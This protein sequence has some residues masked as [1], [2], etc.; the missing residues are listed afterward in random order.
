M[1]N[2][3]NLLDKTKSQIKLLDSLFNE[4]SRTKEDR[5]FQLEQV[6]EWIEDEIEEMRA[7]QRFQLEQKIADWCEQ[8]KMPLHYTVLELLEICK[9]SAKHK[10]QLEKFKT[11]LE[12]EEII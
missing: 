11:Q 9:L 8:E 6:A 2:L 1:K 3:Q 4:K 12:K 5:I 7:E 10:T